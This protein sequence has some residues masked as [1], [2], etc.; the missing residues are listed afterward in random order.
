MSDLIVAI[1]A[2]RIRSGGGVAHLLGILDIEQI[3]V[4]TSKKFTFGV[5][6]NY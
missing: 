6:A 3:D 4:L 1:D 2:S 5:I